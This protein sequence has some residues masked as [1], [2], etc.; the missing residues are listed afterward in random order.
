VLAQCFLPYKDP[1]TDRWHRRNGD[2]SILLTAGA[3][4]DGK[5]PEGFRVIGLPFGA[6]P[7]L[8]QS[9]ICTQAVKL[10]SPVVPVERSMTAM[11]GEL[12]YQAKGG[13]AR[14]HRQLQGA[15]HAL[16]PLRLYPGRSRPREHHAEICRRDADQD[17]RGLVSAAPGPGDALAVRD[18]PDR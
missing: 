1:K 12:G 11:M 16:C 5:A 13:Q 10:Q 18:R 2:F 9:Y 3:L 6:K 15:D 8:F 17:V 4:E 7:R 14:H